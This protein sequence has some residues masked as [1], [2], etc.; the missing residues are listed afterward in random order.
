MSKR[1]LYQ[2]FNAKVVGKGQILCSALHELPASA[3][4]R[5]VTRG[6]PL[7]LAICQTCMDYSEMG[8][9]LSKGDRGWFRIGQ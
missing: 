4:H 9:P 3:S 7:E 2:C 6:A 8:G 1:S 5:A